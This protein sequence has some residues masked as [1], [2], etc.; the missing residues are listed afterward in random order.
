M[1]ITYTT[2]LVGATG[3]LIGYASG[4]KK[5][6]KQWVSD[7]IRD[8]RYNGYT[9]SGSFDEGMYTCTFPRNYKPVLFLQ[10]NQLF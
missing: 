10:I 2:R 7:S 1:A 6:V 5:H 4:N 8:L 9:C 3:D